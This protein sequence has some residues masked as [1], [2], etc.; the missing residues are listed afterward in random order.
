M[1]EGEEIHLDRTA[2]VST[3]QELGKFG[4]TLE[5]SKTKLVEFGRYAQRH[6]SKRGRK[7]RRRFTSWGSPCTAPATRKA[8]FGLGCVRKSHDCDARSCTCRT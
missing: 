4:L 5:L 8:T 1:T 2:E 3:V 7:A 6:A